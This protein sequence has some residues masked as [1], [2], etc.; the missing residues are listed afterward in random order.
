MFYFPSVL[1]LLS[2][3]IVTSGKQA[4]IDINTLILVIRKHIEVKKNVLGKYIQCRLSP[5]G[6][7]Q[8]GDFFLFS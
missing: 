6:G 2:C 8:E 1:H 5:G 3:L 4:E 7:R